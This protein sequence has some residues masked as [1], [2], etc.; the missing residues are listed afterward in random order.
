MLDGVLST[1]T[2][3]EAPAADEVAD[4][5]PEDSSEDL[6][7]AAQTPSESDA[8]RPPAG[9][10]RPSPWTSRRPSP[11]TSRRPSRWSSEAAVLEVVPV[12]A[13]GVPEETPATAR[14]RRRR[15]AS[16]PAGPPV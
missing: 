8:A 13:D 15:A 5:R 7:P 14:P 12:E 4:Y 2:A 1:A 9:E 3:D 11:C 16:R 6:P 10:P